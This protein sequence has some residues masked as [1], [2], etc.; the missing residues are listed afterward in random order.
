MRISVF[1][2]HIN[3]WIHSIRFSSTWIILL[4]LLEKLYC[5]F[6]FKVLKNKNNTTFWNLASPIPNTGG[7]CYNFVGSISFFQSISHN[8]LLS[9]DTNLKESIDWSNLSVRYYLPLILKDS[10]SHIYGLAPFV[11]VPFARALSLETSKDSY[12]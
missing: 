12:L 6:C 11:K 1:L 7:V 9:C 10:D 4:K 5:Q 3:V 2:T 8:I